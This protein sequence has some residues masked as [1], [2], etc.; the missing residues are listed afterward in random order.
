LH[1]WLYVFYGVQIGIIF[2][3]IFT[4]AGSFATSY[5]LLAGARAMVGIGEAS[6]VFKQ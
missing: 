3:S 1:L 4:V 2:W 5:G 6:C